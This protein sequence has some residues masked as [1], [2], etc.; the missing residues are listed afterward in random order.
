LSTVS[1]AAILGVTGIVVSG[2]IGPAIAAYYG[3]R[4]DRQRFAR[5]QLHRS[6]EDLRA[7]LD[8]GAVL[9]GAGETNLRL[10]HEAAS[11]GEPE[12]DEVRDWAGKV[13][14]LGQRLRLR[15]AADAP[16]ITAYES[17]KS[18]LVA[19]GETYGHDDQYPGAV[20]QFEMQRRSF[21]EQARE[22]LERPEAK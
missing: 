2:V 14:L 8:E 15:L 3:R 19:V 9:L 10:A 22:A 20:E 5:D 18:A 16:V 13:H 6:R 21:L 17:V 7:L 11:R 1:N 4:G 12:P